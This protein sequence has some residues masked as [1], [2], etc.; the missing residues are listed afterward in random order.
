MSDKPK[1][2]ERWHEELHGM[3]AGPKLF[4]TQQEFVRV[5]DFEAYVAAI[6]TKKAGKT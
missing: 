2:P 1:M 3:K 5:E 4:D 6:A